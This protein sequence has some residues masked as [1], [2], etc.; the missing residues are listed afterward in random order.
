MINI[1][2]EAEHSPS[3]DKEPHLYALANRYV[4]RC[5]LQ[6]MTG[7]IKKCIAKKELHN[8]QNHEKVN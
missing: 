8:D 1:Y 7:H 5:N 6:A 4:L 3:G 2:L